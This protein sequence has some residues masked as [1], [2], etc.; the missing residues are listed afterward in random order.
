MISF[1]EMPEDNE[2]LAKININF[3]PVPESKS[4]DPNMFIRHMLEYLELEGFKPDDELQFLRSA[5]VEGTAYWIWKFTSDNEKCYATVEK[6]E[7]TTCY[8]CDTDY[9]GL[10]PEQFILGTYHQCF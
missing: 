4:I 7:N 3:L 1:E 9:Y 10:T 8:G 5:L 6:D 2:D